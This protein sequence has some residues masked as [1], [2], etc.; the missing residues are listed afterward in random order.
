MN[1]NLIAF[2]TLFLLCA[3]PEAAYADYYGRQTEGDGFVWYRVRGTNGKDGAED[4]N[5]N[6]LIPAIYDFI[7]YHETADGWF[8]IQKNRKHGVYTPDGRMICDAVYDAAYY[9]KEDDGIWIKFEQNGKTGALDGYGNVLVAPSALYNDSF[10]YTFDGFNYKNSA[11][12]YVPIGVFLTS[13]ST[14][15]GTEPGSIRSSN[16]AGVSSRERVKESNG[17]V[18][19]KIKGTNGLYGAEDENGNIVIPMKY[20]RLY[21]VETSDGWFCVVKDNK[22]GV[23]TNDGYMICDA[24]YDDVL[25]LHEDD[26]IW[27]KIVQDGKTGGIDFNGNVIVT[28]NSLYNDSFFYSL[29]EFK[30]KNSAGN[31]VGIGISLRGRPST[32]GSSAAASGSSS[33][34]GSGGV[35]GNSHPVNPTPTTRMPNKKGKGN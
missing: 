12:K 15:G 4:V 6:T 21:H 3:F 16:S 25:Y 33:V 13:G 8:G 35:G 26:G 28:P 32:G 17:F 5:G 30:Y 31:Y 22:E 20:D 1:K 27:V 7:V 34:T 19:Y 11:G 9:R 14:T 29:G 23:Y 2:I 24:I 18:W 10:F